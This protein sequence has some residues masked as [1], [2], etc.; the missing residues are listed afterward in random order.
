[1]GDLSDLSTMFFFLFAG[2]FEHYKIG[3]TSNISVQVELKSNIRQAL[4]D[5]K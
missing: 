1:M 2:G 3:M 4:R 5:L